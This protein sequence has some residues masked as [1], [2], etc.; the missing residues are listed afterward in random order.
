[1]IRDSWFMTKGGKMRDL[2]LSLPLSFSKRQ[3]GTWNSTQKWN[4]VLL[5]GIVILAVGYLVQISSLG[6]KGYDIKKVEQKI[7]LLEDEQKTLQIE[8]SNL[9]S[10][11][12]I[13]TQAVK[14]NFVPS[15]NVSYIQNSNF[16]LK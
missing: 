6:T 7:Q 15:T 8:S 16:A 4:L 13:Q 14:L 3:S 9:Q 10:M 1:M 11:D 2:T 12:Q 5:I